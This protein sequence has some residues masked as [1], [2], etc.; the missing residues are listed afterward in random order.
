MIGLNVFF[1]ILFLVI[2]NCVVLI[3]FSV[4]CIWVI[5]VLGLFTR[6]TTAISNEGWS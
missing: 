4:I 1:S 2:N 6:L 3:V 5:I